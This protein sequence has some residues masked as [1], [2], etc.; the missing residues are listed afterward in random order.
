MKQTAM[1]KL[2][3]RGRP[4]VMPKIK[5]PAGLQAGFS[6]NHMTLTA[7]K[8]EQPRKP[9]VHKIPKKGAST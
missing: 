2:A 8:P 1:M 4:Q 9:I 3:F 7:A 5:F 6:D